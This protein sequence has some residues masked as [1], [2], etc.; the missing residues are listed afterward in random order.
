MLPVRVMLRR[1]DYDE[2]LSSAERRST[3]IHGLQTDLDRMQ[4]GYDCWLT[5]C[6]TCSYLALPWDDLYLI[7]WHIWARKLLAG[8]RDLIDSPIGRKV[9][10]VL[11]VYV[12]KVTVAPPPRCGPRGC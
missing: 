5:H 1:R 2:V 10:M 3:S 6:G 8:G 7:T 11:A 4:A 9:P 12:P